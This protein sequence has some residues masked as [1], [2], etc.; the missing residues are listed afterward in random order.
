MTDAELIERARSDPAAFRTLYDRYAGRIHR[1]H[2]R[3]TRHDEAALDLTAETFAQAW[4]SRL[5][6]A[7]AAGGSAGPWLYG[8]ARHVLLVSVRRGRL[9]RR[10]C[11]R[12]GV[13]EALDRPPATVAPQERWLDGLDEALADLPAAQ[14]E[15]LVLRVVADLGYDEI[16][17]HL[18]T[19][20]EAARARV[21]RGLTTLRSQLTDPT[22]A[23][24]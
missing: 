11:E 17:D 12:L 5:R 18:S 10:A 4:V 20:E 19:T 14:R 13:M 7:D 22:E 16:A 9:E 6:F 8:I 2:L 24:P 23:R 3:R 15:A 21:S 1:Y